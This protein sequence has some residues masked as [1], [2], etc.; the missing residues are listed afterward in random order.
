MRPQ[1]ICFVWRHLNMVRAI[2]RKEYLLEVR[3]RRIDVPSFQEYP[4]CLPA[5]RNL[6]S[7][8]FESPVTFLVGENGCGKSTLLEAIAVAWGFN[9]EGGSRNF[10]FTTRVAHSELHRYIRLSRGVKHAKD[11]F[12]LR[13]E[14]FFNVASE[15]DKLD[16]EP[17]LSPPIINSYGGT[18][19]HAQSHGESFLTLLTERFGGFGFYVLDEP[20]AALSPARQL[21][22]LVQVHSL[23]RKTSQFIIATHSPIVMSYPNAQILLLEA[24]GIRRVAFEETEHYRVMKQYLNHY[25]TMLETLLD[26]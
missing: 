6:D 22:L 21:S 3:L 16:E 24:N 11:G 25:P 23:V 8:V 18:S 14:S 15:I 12:F 9:A 20:E 2:D 26:R 10:R 7:I 17:S 1:L 19:L 4:F 13:A 5:V